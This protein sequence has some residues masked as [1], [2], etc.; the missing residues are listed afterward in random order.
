MGEIS[1]IK[2]INKIMKTFCIIGLGISG[3]VSSRYCL[4]HGFKIKVLEK[5]AD[6]GGVWLTKTY[7]GIRLQT[8]KYSYAFSDF[9]HSKKT[10]LYPTKDELLLYFNRYCSKHNIKNYCE[11]NSHVYNTEYDSKNNKWFVYYKNHITNKRTRIIV[12]Y[13]IVCSGIYNTK[14]QSVKTDQ[15][16]TKIIYPEQLTPNNINNL[17]N[18]NIVIIGNGPTGCDIA[19]L[20]YK[21]KANK[22]TLLYRSERWIF[23]RYL[24]NTIS[25]H[26]FL[27][28]FNMKMAK[29]LPKHIYIICL[30][31]IYYLLYIIGHKRLSFNIKTPYSVV[32][33][34]NLVLNESI[35]DLINNKSIDYIKT[36]TITIKNNKINYDN[37][38]MEYDYCFIC[39]GYN[40]NLKFIGLDKLPDLYNKIIHPNLK[41]CAFIGFA[42][43]FNWIQVSELQIRWYLDY[44]KRELNL[45]T[46][47]NLIKNENKLETDYLYNDLAVNA[48]HY[49][50]K[51]SNAINL[52]SKYNFIQF[53][54]WFKAVEFDF[55]G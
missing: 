52:K 30:T 51:L 34:S 27:C 23:Q 26:N 16:N 53:N 4:S 12:D 1:Q 25:T 43:S 35:L 14:K 37:T 28:R 41:Q 50:D 36:D 11:F 2:S 24:W 13:L 54:Y 45:K 38:T 7:P 46:I 15:I 3:M 9:P 49:C 6:I 40:T 19:E 32:N 18:K 17:N 33:R 10:G 39:T 31:I 21:Y 48:Y 20:C 29:I 44:I 5:E 22:I 42:E 47:I 55:W 8:T